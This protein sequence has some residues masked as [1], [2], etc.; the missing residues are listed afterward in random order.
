MINTQERV[1]IKVLLDS[2]ATD[3]VISSE[4]ARK[5]GFKL[6]KMKKTNICEKYRQYF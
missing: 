5:Q 4:F 3:L 1:I 6:K 2:G